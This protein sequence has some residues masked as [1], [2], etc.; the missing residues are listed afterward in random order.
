MSTKVM[1]QK[2]QSLGGFLTAMI[3]PN[4]GAFI[5]W[6]LLTAMFIPTGWF[7]NEFF[8]QLKDPILKY[9]LPLLVGYTGGELVYKKRGGVMGALLTMGCI[10]GT[11]ITMLAGA[12]ILGPLGGWI[13]KKFDKLIDGKI[14]S[15]FEMLVNNFSIGIIGMVFCLLTQSIAGPIFEGL[16]TFFS[17]G[18]QWLMDKGLMILYPIFMEPA[19]MLF[20]NNAISQG[21]FAPLGVEQAAQAGKSIF[22]LLSSNPG[23]GLGMLLAYWLYGKGT[24]KE[25]APSAIIIHFFGGI[26]ELY[27]PY[28][29]M[30]PKLIIATIA[31]WMSGYVTYSVIGA[32]LIA[33]PSPGSI[34]SYILMTP[35]GCYLQTFS[36]VLVATAVS[37]LLS[38]LILK[39]DKSAEADFQD[40]IVMMEGFKGKES[41]Y[42][43][44][45]KAEKAETK[46][47]ETKT[48]APV[49]KIIFACDAG[50]GSSAMGASVLRKKVQAAGLDIEVTNTAIEKIPEDADVIVCHEGLYERAKAVAP[51][52]NFVVITNFLAAP[53][54][55]ELIQRLKDNQ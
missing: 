3:L 38:S 30:K 29:L 27:F 13:I 10:V 8:A 46:K 52:G 54:Y 55:E 4:I 1:K 24:A 26:H 35:K 31:G 19:R 14:P 50:M 28:I 43:A 15:G 41:R 16:N 40:S 20:L 48:V 7:P 6:G 23:P 45:V 11:S 47:V 36:G 37:F 44:D 2:V 39:V 22:F 42:F 32:G 34:I 25:A 5:A 51:N 53:E 21:I 49:H 17:S 18:V 12:M 9:L 33:Y